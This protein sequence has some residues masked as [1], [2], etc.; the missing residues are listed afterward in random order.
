MGKL[1]TV[2]HETMSGLGRV[3]N[4]SLSYAAVCETLI[5]SSKVEE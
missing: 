4:I 3:E 2:G 5:S 1:C